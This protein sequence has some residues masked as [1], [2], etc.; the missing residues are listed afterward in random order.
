[1]SQNI[2]NTPPILWELLSATSVE[3]LN[4]IYKGEFSEDIAHYLLLLAE[5]NIERDQ[6][7]GRVK[8]RVF[9]ILVES[10]QNITRHQDIIEE[11]NIQK[12]LFSIQKFKNI[13][14]V[15]TSNLVKKTKIPYLQQ[16]LETINSMSE[17]ELTQ[18]YKDVLIEDSFTAKGGA[19]LGLIEIAR[20][21]G[22]KLLYDFK[23][24]D[25]NYSFFYMHTFIKLNHDQSDQK[26]SHVYLPRTYSFDFIKNIH[27]VLEK[28]NILLVYCSVFDQPSLITLISILNS[29]IK[30]Q[31]PFRKKVISTLVEMLQNIIHHGYVRKG[32]KNKGALGMF[33]ISQKD[34]IFSL[35]TIN[36]VSNKDAQELRS[37]LDYINSL[38]DKELEEVYNN[39]LLNFSDEEA[40]LGGLGFLEMRLKSGQPLLYEIKPINEFISYFALKVN[41]D[42]TQEKN[43]KTHNKKD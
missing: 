16:K 36:Y 38:D 27:E 10:V 20:K 9:H 17:E 5:K 12:A 42:K 22:N 40:N 3:D 25:Q 14:L 1:M 4:Y 8:K 30:G 39:Q 37:Y 31:L 32:Q 13:Y 21:S 28:E 35:N 24:F 18:F 7:K 19:G 2:I 15:T 34:P 23:D 26:E 41:F 29:Q 6:L 33:Y 11:K 43:G